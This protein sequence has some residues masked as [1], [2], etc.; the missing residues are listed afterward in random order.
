MFLSL[1]LSLSSFSLPFLPSPPSFS[2]YIHTLVLQTHE[3]T[4]YFTTSDCKK[5]FIASPRIAR[6]HV[7]K[8]QIESSIYVTTNKWR[9]SRS[10]A[11][12]SLHR[13]RRLQ[14]GA[15]RLGSQRLPGLTATPGLPCP[16]PAM[17]GRR[18]SWLGCL[19][20]ASL[21]AAQTTPLPRVSPSSFT[22][23]GHGCVPAPRPG[24]ADCSVTEEPCAARV[25]GAGGN[26]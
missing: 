23:V 26:V 7:S 13:L 16:W 2:V 15:G 6:G 20:S 3:I 9:G 11:T 4:Q 14:V 1:P 24:T 25:R 5:G 18:L 21:L 8:L 19:G 10:V 12:A 17:A 22:L